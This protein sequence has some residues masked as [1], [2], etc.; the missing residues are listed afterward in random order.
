MHKQNKQGFTIVEL[1]IVIVVIGILAA[2]TIVAFNGVQARAKDG[3]RV[4]DLKSVMKLMEMFYVDNG[5]YPR[6]DRL[7]PSQI[8]A[9]MTNLLKV[10]NREIFL[11][12]GTT[13]SQSSFIGYVGGMTSGHYTYKSWM[14]DGTQCDNAT[15]APSESVCIRYSVWY[16]SEQTG[17]T[18]ELK[19]ANGN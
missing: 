2:I 9:T 4:S 14:T 19:G 3:E 12:P 18:I 6:I 1:L 8:D 10:T 16:K 13:N 11:A 17:A 5:Y 7:N 15:V